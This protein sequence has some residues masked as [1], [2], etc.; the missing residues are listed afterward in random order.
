MGFSFKTSKLKNDIKYIKYQFSHR[1]GKVCRWLDMYYSN[2][3]T[4]IFSSVTTMSIW[5][6]LKNLAWTYRECIFCHFWAIVPWIHPNIMS[7]LPFYLFDLYYL[8]E[9]AP[10]FSSWLVS[11]GTSS[12]HFK[13]LW[14]P[15][16]CRLHGVEF[17][18]TCV[19]CC[20]HLGSHLASLLSLLGN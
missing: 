18:I 17:M 5:I 14:I 11:N 10:I 6:I 19:G 15:W 7:N 4:L 1:F 20:P 2:I 9:F 13:R 3:R 12:L 8:S 16:H